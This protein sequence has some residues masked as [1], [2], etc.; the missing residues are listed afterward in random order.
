MAEPS[1]TTAGRLT[2]KQERFA[3]ALL[4][5]RSQSEAYRIAYN[6]ENMTPESIKVEAC[7][8]ANKP[9][10]VAHVAQLKAELRA[11]HDISVDT[12]TEELDENRR[13]AFEERAPSAAIQATMG[14]A[15]LHGLLVDKREVSTPQ[16][17][18]F[19]MVL[20]DEKPDNDRIPGKPDTP[21]LPPG[22]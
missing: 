2:L 13:L 8:T 15:K 6:A 7:V 4:E 5:T 10:V 9:Q 20:G 18:T 1:K 12:L 11:R 21:A 19:K 22:E 3:E 14:K 16:G 17:V